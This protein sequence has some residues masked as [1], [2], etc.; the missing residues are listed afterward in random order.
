VR[1]IKTVLP[2]LRKLPPRT[3]HPLAY[4]CSVPIYLG[5]K[6]PIPKT[7]Y[8][9]MVQHFP[10]AHLHKI[11]YDQLLPDVAHYYRRAEVEQLFAGL[12]VQRVNIHHNRGYS[13][14]VI[15]E[16]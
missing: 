12:D 16:R 9:A 13:W 15:C 5:L 10:F 7:D 6:L 1:F 8:M 14:T 11:V 3:V 2:L 4:V